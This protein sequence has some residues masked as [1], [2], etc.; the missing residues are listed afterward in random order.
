M[1]NETN[2][3]HD[4]VDEQP[5]VALTRR[6]IIRAGAW[7]APVVASVSALPLAAATDPVGDVTILFLN[8]DDDPFGVDV[9]DTVTLLF[10]IEQGGNGLSGGASASLFGAGGIAAWIATSGD[11]LVGVAE[12]GIFFGEVEVLGHG[13]FTVSVSYGATARQFSVTFE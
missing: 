8:G 12:D 7:A 13:T 1:T 11:H 3:H 10:Q 4:L 9:G 6:G 2:T 5:P